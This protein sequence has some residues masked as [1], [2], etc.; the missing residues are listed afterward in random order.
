MPPTRSAFSVCSTQEGA[1]IEHDCKH[2]GDH[3]LRNICSSGLGRIPIGLEP[4]KAGDELEALVY[5][6]ALS[7]GKFDDVQR[8]VHIRRPGRVNDVKNELD[9]VFTR[10]GVMVVCSCKSGK[11]ITKE[12]LYELSSLSRRESAG[13]Y[14]RKIL[15]CQSAELDQPI[16]DR[17]KESGIRLIY[18]TALQNQLSDKLY[19]AIHY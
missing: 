10:N 18:G 5:E 19:A 9:V 4:P 13:I 1:I 6:T 8:N 16:K 2:K 11:R 15:I 17:A 12:M 3:G 14:C 7:C